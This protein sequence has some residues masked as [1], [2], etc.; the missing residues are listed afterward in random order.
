M[1]RMIER[2]Y[3]ES[4]ND[5]LLD[6]DA[7]ALLGPRQVG[8]TTLA[9]SILRDRGEDAVYLDLESAADRRKLSDPEAY[10]AAH[11]DKLVILDEIQRAPELFPILRGQIDARRQQGRV[12]GHFLILGSASMELLR[13]SSESLAG[14]ISQIELPP[15]QPQELY[16]ASDHK[17]ES[18]GVADTSVALEVDVDAPSTTQIQQAVEALW[19]RGGFPKSY[20]AR[21]DAASIRWRLDFIRTYL[22]RD[23][24]Q[25]GL[26][27]AADP[28]E[29]FWRML[30]HDQGGEFTAERFADG[31]DVT[32]K[33]AKHYLS[34]LE[35]LLLV[36]TLGP[37]ASSGTRR[38]IKKPKVYVRDPGLLH[39]LLDI[40]SHDQLLGHPIV[41]KS[42]EGF[43]IEA[44]I[45]SSG[46]NTPAYFY[47]SAG[48]AELDLILEF[49]GEN[50]WAIEIKKSTAPS[51]R[52]RF[53]E[54]ADDIKA[55][56]RIVVHGGPESFPM[57]QGV[58]AMS[59]R[60][61]IAAVRAVG[62]GGL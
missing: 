39:A 55:A 6:S 62:F 5:R 54:A 60:D 50:R 9:R 43:V 13:Q 30:A 12:G 35:K 38:L 44:L 14:R 36:R 7:V 10:L 11:T 46:D 17:M 53:Y 33:T 18:S 8:K 41:G 42:W 51:L 49:S 22:E 21:N 52:R 58:E 16:A 34:I 19:L 25:F 24:P 56:R 27:V 15:L 2:L 3:L 32:G 59:L 48:G 61:A 26:R 28:M 57:P 31:L 37:W 20:L 29:K 1:V 4:I 45:H 40:R 47:R 23:M